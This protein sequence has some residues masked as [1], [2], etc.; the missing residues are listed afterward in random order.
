MDIEKLKK[1]PALHQ[2]TI[3]DENII[4]NYGE[5]IT[6]W[7]RDH[8][9]IN[10]YFDFYKCQQDANEENLFAVIRKLIL[11]SDGSPAL[12][13]GEV[14]PIDISIELLVKINDF[15]GKL[16]TKPLMQET[17]NVQK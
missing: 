6:F 8:I 9:D 11:K 5:P 13:E 14:L 15:L 7:M 17:G 10:T 2:L 1:T 12:T 4:K 3:D 16:R